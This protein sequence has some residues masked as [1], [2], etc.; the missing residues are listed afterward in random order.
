MVQS[1]DDDPTLSDGTFAL[2]LS[3]ET[4]EWLEC[5]SGRDLDRLSPIKTVDI[6][7]LRDDLANRGTQSDLQTIRE[8]LT[9]T[10]YATVNGVN[11][12]C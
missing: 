6:E 5:V 9:V 2:R 8:Q 1:K 3:G 7:M 11:S 12:R 10:G 4:Q